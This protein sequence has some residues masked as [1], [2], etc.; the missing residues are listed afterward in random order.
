MGK[1]KLNIMYSVALVMAYL[2]HG[3]EQKLTF[4]R[5][6]THRFGCVLERFFLS[7]GTKSVTENIV[8]WTYAHGWFCCDSMHFFSS[9][10]LVPTDIMILNWGIVN[11]VVLFINEVN[12]S[13]QWRAI[14]FTG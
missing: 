1:E 11:P 2:V 7:V 13:C 10:A 5:F 6:A 8:Y 12:F 14:V 4:C 3:W 9:W